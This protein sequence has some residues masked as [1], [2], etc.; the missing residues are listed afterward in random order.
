MMASANTNKTILYLAVSAVLI[1]LAV[2]LW[3][4]IRK[5]IGGGSS[6]TGGGGGAGGAGAAYQ[7]PY[8]QQPQQPGSSLGASL[9]MGSGSGSGSGDNQNALNNALQQVLGYFKS[10]AASNVANI[11]VD[12][13]DSD[14]ASMDAAGLPYELTQNLPLQSWFMTDLL[15]PGETDTGTPV[16]TASYD[17]NAVNDDLD[18]L[19]LYNDASVIS[20]ADD[21]SALSGSDAAL[22]TT[23]YI[24]DDY[25]SGDYGS[26][27]D[28]GGS[29]G[30]YAVGDYGGGD[31]GDTEGL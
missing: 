23:A 29:D 2:K 17:P 22:D 16:E 7:N 31:A 4:A 27:G 10:E 20:S 6:G 18:Q 11:G 25:L 15:Y 21:T 1:F 8:Q 13:V 28:Y 14:L 5:A 24:G 30:G 12:S 19:D 9:G 3:P 26:Y